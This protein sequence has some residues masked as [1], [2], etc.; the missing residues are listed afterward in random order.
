MIELLESVDWHLL[1]CTYYE[2]QCSNVKHV[3]FCLHV[4]NV[5]TWV[6]WSVYIVV[7]FSKRGVLNKHA[8]AVQWFLTLVGLLY[9]VNWPTELFNSGVKLLLEPFR[10]RST[11]RGGQTC[12]KVRMYK[13]SDKSDKFSLNYSNLFRGPLFFGTQCTIHYKTV[14]CT[15]CEVWNCFLDFTTDV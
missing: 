3:D 9:V 7:G 1:I 13:I 12:F 4:I 5:T 10:R 14:T 6:T 11:V 8:T 2:I 15:Q